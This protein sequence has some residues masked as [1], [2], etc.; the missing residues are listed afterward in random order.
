MTMR[1]LGADA[2]MQ[3]DQAEPEDE[4]G[5]QRRDQRR[6]RGVADDDRKAT[7]S[8]PTKCIDQMPTPSATAALAITTLRAAGA[9]ALMPVVSCSPVKD[10]AIASATDTAT[11][12][13]S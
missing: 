10:A 6:Q 9:S 2:E 7:A 3:E 12:T 4:D 5:D 1:L 13:G 8:M 11:K